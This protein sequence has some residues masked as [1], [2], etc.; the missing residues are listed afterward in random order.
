MRERLASGLREHYG[1][2]DADAYDDAVGNVMR[3]NVISAA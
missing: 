1:Y 3:L 2:D